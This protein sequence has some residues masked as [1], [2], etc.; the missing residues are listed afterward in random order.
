MYVIQITAA[1]NQFALGNPNLDNNY[2]SKDHVVS[3]AFMIASQLGAVQRFDNNYSYPNYNDKNGAQAAAWH[4]GRYMEVG[5]DGTRYVG[6]R[7]PTKEEID[8]I[9]TYQNDNSA[10]ETITKVLSGAYYWTLDGTAAS[11]SGGDGGTS[12]NAYVR[13]IRDLTD[14]DLKRL[15]QQHN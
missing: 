7:L 13:C 3:P 1:S 6:W 14:D 11:V 5:T 15:A 4:C 2:Q 8:V 12:T 10:S 9:I